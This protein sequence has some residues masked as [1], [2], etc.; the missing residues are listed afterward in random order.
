MNAG[1]QLQPKGRLFTPSAAR[2]KESAATVIALLALMLTPLLDATLLFSLMTVAILVYIA[3]FRRLMSRGEVVL[4][5]AAFI[6]AAVVA[7]VLGTA[8]G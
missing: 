5:V 8:T 7:L 1:K 4:A 2:T 3:V 6:V